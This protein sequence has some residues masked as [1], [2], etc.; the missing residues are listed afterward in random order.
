MSARASPVDPYCG[1]PDLPDRAS[2]SVFGAHGSYL[3]VAYS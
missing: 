1:H 3:Y 2:L